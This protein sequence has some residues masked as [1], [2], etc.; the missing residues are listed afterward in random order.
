ML[1]IAAMP[2]QDSS[3]VWQASLA[4]LVVFVGLEGLRWRWPRL[5]PARAPLPSDRRWLDL[6]LALLVPAAILG[7]GQLWFSGHLRWRWPG[8][9]RHL[10][11]V[12]AQLL[13]WSPLGVALW[14]RRQPIESLWV[15]RRDVLLR[16]FAGALLGLLAVAVYLTCTGAWSRW[17]A[18]LARTV[19]LQAW[20]HAVPVFLEACGVAF[21]FVRL[22]WALGRWPAA[23]VPGLLFAAAHVPRALADGEAS[24]A[25]AVMFVFQTALIAVL[26]TWTARFRDLIAIGVA[27]WL[28]DLAID[29]F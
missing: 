16:T 17:P 2:S 22:E 10:A 12:L 25:I 9:W 14:L 13:I 26:I 21:V 15:P 23:L 8:D 5:W 24:G 6:S 1:R 7:G 4:W 29:A 18:I 27:H 3:F 11:Y 28:W 20:A 19:T